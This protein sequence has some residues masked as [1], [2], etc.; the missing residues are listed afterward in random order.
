MRRPWSTRAA[1]P[2]YK[3]DLHASR[4]RPFNGIDLFS[5][6]LNWITK[7]GFGNNGVEHG[8]L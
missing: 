5:N 6:K 2:R 4:D 3:Q 7:L 1:A 8:I